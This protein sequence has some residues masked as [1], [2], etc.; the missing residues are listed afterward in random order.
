MDRVN[1]AFTSS[2]FYLSQHYYCTEG[3]EVMKFILEKSA[4]LSFVALKIIVFSALIL[5]IT[6]C[7]S[8]KSAEQ[9]E[10]ELIEIMF[11]TMEA[12]LVESE[13]KTKELEEQLQEQY[14]TATPI[15]SQESREFMATMIPNLDIRLAKRV[16]NE[17][18]VNIH[19]ITEWKFDNTGEVITGEMKV[20][21]ARYSIF[22][23][24]KHDH[25]EG[26]IGVSDGLFTK[27]KCYVGESDRKFALREIT[28]KRVA[29]HNREEPYIPFYF[30]GVVGAEPPRVALDVYVPKH[31]ESL[32]VGIEV[33]NMVTFDVEECNVSLR[34]FW[35]K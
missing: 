31:E 5:V 4:V 16:S 28:H 33:E 1:V 11:A 15:R 19:E 7:G 12:E 9:Q 6:G 17:D 30:K 21:P 10:E 23:A 35:I 20:Y 13:K 22:D 3:I 34:D 25:I 2:E 27:I 18:F 32:Y 24:I 8:E 14:L 26:F 29:L